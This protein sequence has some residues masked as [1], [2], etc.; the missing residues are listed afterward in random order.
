M[1]TRESSKVI[2]KRIKQSREGLAH[3]MDSAGHVSSVVKISENLEVFLEEIEQQVDA[4]EEKKES[5][6]K[7]LISFIS[8]LLPFNGLLTDVLAE[9]KKLF[10]HV[11]WR[12]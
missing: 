7:S 3:L 5:K 9:A 4:R 1:D 12:N 10:D 8:L 11:F 6:L 2:R